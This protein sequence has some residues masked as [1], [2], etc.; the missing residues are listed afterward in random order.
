MVKNQRHV[1][2][3]QRLFNPQLVKNEARLEHNRLLGK[4]V[5]IWKDLTFRN[6]FLYHRFPLSK[7]V[8]ENVCPMLDEVRRFQLDESLGDEFGGYSSDIDEWDVLKD[9]TLLK[10]VRN[11]TQLQIQVGDRCEVISGQ[12]QG[13][14]G[15]IT[16]ISE[17]QVC[18]MHT[19]D[20]IPIKIKVAARELQKFF[21]QGESVR[22][23]QGIHAGEPG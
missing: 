12:F 15:T 9:A 4:K 21:A 6:G 10:T 7:L 8:H 14:K 13:C 18:I 23:L 5:Y 11:D 1:K 16:E 22:I 19:L 17:S 20:K 2:I 3:P